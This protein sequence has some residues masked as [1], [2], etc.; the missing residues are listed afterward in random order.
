MGIDPGLGVVGALG[1][2]DGE[3]RSRCRR[4]AGA[5]RQSYLSLSVENVG[6]NPLVSKTLRPA[7]RRRNHLTCPSGVPEGHVGERQVVLQQCSLALGLGAPEQRQAGDAGSNGGFKVACLAIAVR[8]TVEVVPLSPVV[9]GAGQRA[10]LLEVGEGRGVVAVS[11]FVARQGHDQTEVKGRLNVQSGPDLGQDG[12]Q[13][14]LRFGR[15]LHLVLGG[16]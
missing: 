9:E 14:S 12:V 5:T 4:L 10:D 11:R 2:L 15:I 7:A 1:H 6:K 16:R 3:R 8:E 13:K